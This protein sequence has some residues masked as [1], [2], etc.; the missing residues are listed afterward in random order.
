[1]QIVQ[2]GQCN[3]RRV[4][5]LTSPDAGW[6]ATDQLPEG[7]GLAGAIGAARAEGLALATWLT[8]R[9]ARSEQAVTVDWN[10]CTWSDDSGTTPLA[11]PISAPE[12]WAAGVTYKTSREARLEETGQ[13]GS[14]YA[15]VY[16]AD[17]PELFMKDNAERRTVG[18]LEP[19]GVR[20]D[21]ALS[22]PEPEF[23]L[24]LDR[25]ANIVGVTLGNDVTARD[26]EAENPLYLPQAKIFAASCSLGPAVTILDEAVSMTDYFDLVLTITR[27]GAEVFRGETNT[28]QLNRSFEDLA[29]HVSRY[30]VLADGTVLLTGTGV[31]PPMELGL[32]DGDV[33]Q[34][35]STQLGVLENPVELLDEF[36]IPPA[37]AVNA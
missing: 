2:T 5:V 8:A 20:G 34:I 15:D 26:I 37:E 17:R 13:K 7:V 27:N 19:I 29:R 4:A 10:A 30:N 6:D 32:R 31:I 23:A 21:S 36:P 25:E 24:V 1:M 33:V 14:F 9:A 16:D 12:V 28:D 35:A 11:V 22:V 18:P 3:R